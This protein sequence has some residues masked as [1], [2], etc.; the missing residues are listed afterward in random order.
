MAAYRNRYGRYKTDPNLQAAHAAAAWIVTLDDHEL[1]GDWADEIP[2]DPDLQTPEAFRARRVAAFQ[3]YY[4]HMPLRRSSMPR[5]LDMRLYRQA[6]F[7]RLAS[8]HVLDT[9][10]YRSDQPTTLE[11][12]YD[13]TRTMTGAEQE[14][15]LVR[16]MSQSGTRWNLLANQAMWAQNDR[17]AGPAQTF[18]FDCWDGYRVQR[19]RLLEFFGSGRTN[20]P[21]VLTGDRHCTW[22]C[23]LKPDFED[24]NSP[25]VGAELTGTSITSGGDPNRPAFHAKWDPIKAESPHWK[26]ID[27]RRGYM[28]CDVNDERLRASLRAVS[29]VL[30]PTAT[31]TTAATFEV[32]AGTPGVKV[33]S[34]DGPPPPA[35]ARAASGYIGVDDQP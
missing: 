26:Y 13:P 10:Q 20:N 33:V 12:A 9:R 35:A 19:K 25:V 32:V 31:I 5:G 21:V 22:V 11:G 16:G 27:I 14:N 3:A 30:G 2:N 24:P 34:S 6:R 18:S 15:W 4:E 28:L 23:D 8:L 1:D 7:G 17:T 29:T